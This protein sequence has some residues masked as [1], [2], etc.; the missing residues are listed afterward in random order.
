MIRTD[1]F[2]YLPDTVIT[3][4]SLES[5][6][7]CCKNACINCPFGYTVKKHGLLFKKIDYD[8]IH[9]ISKY[10]DINIVSNYKDY[11]LVILK[12]FLIAIIKTDDLF[13]REMHIHDLI[14]PKNIT[15][16]LIESYYFY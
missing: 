15:K 11:D 1:R 4:E 10:F 8:E 6:P 16:E 13:V 3:S 14:S 2:E 12:G 5:K 9:D 7:R